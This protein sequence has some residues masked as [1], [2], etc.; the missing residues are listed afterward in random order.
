MNK[1]DNSATPEQSDQA[2]QRELLEK[3][4]K[5]WDCFKFCVST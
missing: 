5:E 1:P 3:F 2:K 4:D